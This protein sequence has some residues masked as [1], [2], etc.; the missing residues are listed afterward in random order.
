MPVNPTGADLKRMLAEDTEPPK[1]IAMLNLLKFK[2]GGR[3][4]YEEYVRRFGTFA[5]RVGAELIYVGDC[6]TPL[7][8][9]EGFDW[10]VVLLVRYP[11]RRAFSLMVADPDYQ[12]ITGLRTGALEE[13]VLQVTVPWSE[14]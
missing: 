3:A 1:P 13:A 8:T 2:E 7:V 10:D 4:D 12:E 11:S 5:D 14:A 6:S 9:P